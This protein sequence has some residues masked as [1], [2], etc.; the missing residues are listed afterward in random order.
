MTDITIRQVFSSRRPIDRTI[1]KVIDYYAQEEKR[2]AAEVAEYEVTE[3]IESCFGRFL[4]A[5]G[6]GVRGGQAAE[7]GI[8]VS[9]FYGSGKSSFTKYLG[10]ALDPN[11]KVEGKPFLDLLCDR[12]NTKTIPATLRTLSKNFPAAVVMLDLGA[13]QLAESSAAPVSTVLY[14]KVLQWAGFSREKKTARLEFTLDRR[15]LYGDFKDRYRERFRGEWEEIHNDPLIGVRRAS[16]I[17]PQVLPDDFPTPE[18]FSNL[19]FEEAKDARNLAAEIIDICRRRTGRDNILILV[20]EAGQYVAPRGE[21]IL[22]LDGLA[23]NLKELGKGKVWIAATGQQTLSE[24]VEKAAYNSAELNKLRDRFPISIHLDASDIREITRRRLLGK[25][26]DGRGRLEALFK[27][28]GQSMAYHTR[29]SGTSLFKGNPD[30]VTFAGLYPF[31]PQ[32]FDLLLE[33]IRALGHSTGGIGLRSAI[34]VIQDVLVDKSRILAADAVKLADRKLGAL[35]RVDD[36]YD[37]LR[38][39]IAKVSPHAVTAVDKVASI[40]G[41]GAFETRVAKAVAALQ[42]METFSRTGQNIA[43]LLYEKLGSPVIADQVKEALNKIAAEK[44]CGLVEDTQTGGWTFLSDAVKPFLERRNG[45]APNSGERTRTKVELLKQGAGAHDLFQTQPSAKLENA[46]IVNASVKLGTAPVVGSQEAVELRLEFVDPALWDAKRIELLTTT[47]RPELDNVIFLVAKTDEA[48]EDWLAEIVRSE[49]ILRDFDERTA[50]FGVAQYLRAERQAAESNRTRAAAAMETAMLDGVFIFRGR[51]TPVREAA[52]TLDAAVRSVLSAAVR[53]VFPK[54][55]LAKI[56]PYTDLAAKFL[57]VERLKHITKE[58]DPLNLVDK[59]KGRIDIS[60]RTLMEVARVFRTKADDSGTGRVTGSALQN[61]FSGP[62]YGWSKDAVRYLFAALLRAG[63]IEFHVQG[64]RG[65]V[66]TAGEQAVEAVKSTV[67]FNKI[68][69]SPRDAKV[70]DEALERTA[71]RLENLFGEEVLPL[72][73][74][75]IGTVQSR[76]PG[77]GE[78]LGLAPLPDSLRLLGLQGE[79]RARR[80]LGDVAELLKGEAGGIASVFGGPQ[81]DFIGELDWAKSISDTLKTGG[82]ADIK[83]ARNMLESLKD[84]ERLHPGTSKDLLNDPD[85]ADMDEIL[86][87]ERF[88]ERL[89]DLR[90]LIRAVLDAAGKRYAAERAAHEDELKKALANVQDE[91]DWVRLL[92]EDRTEIAAKLVCDLP[93]SADN[94]D[95]VELLKVLL[96]RKLG[97]PALMVVVKAE[98]GLRC[99]AIPETP[100]SGDSERPSLDISERPASAVERTAT[101]DSVNLNEIVLAPSDLLRPIVL[102]SSADLEPWLADLRKRLEGLLNSGGRIRIVGQ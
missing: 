75:I 4:D 33:L 78:K 55:H 90:G 79:D 19:R 45:Y 98:V 18:I 48:V 77:L 31:L 96:T 20:D 91:P 38:A 12:F 7:I 13:E 62:P 100:S 22:N 89:P 41:A 92:D 44:E 29:L 54:Y 14:W 39:D 16:E 21:L 8:W 57:G 81:C 42:P 80:L 76:F 49:I 94:G 88:F 9:G 50:D 64:A 84:L 95:P 72:E 83:T 24:I 73:E 86:S 85:R 69:V 40:F 5:Y 53:E 43:A 66:I 32:H 101:A 25:S 15:G 74:N 82:E 87:S 47:N 46:K 97:L 11:V 93:P 30:S 70:P 58:L 27:Q 71:R 102:A 17:V 2:L 61:F 99:P 36:F 37:T 51:Q 59:T 23:R 26:D 67:A 60:N 52:G 3:N 34:R 63:E 10:A 28:H 56:S 1:E 65:P 68:G 6:D 35:A